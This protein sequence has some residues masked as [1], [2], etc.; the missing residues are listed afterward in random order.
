M[1]Q[2]VPQEALVDLADVLSCSSAILAK[3]LGLTNCEI[4]CIREDYPNDSREQVYQ[5]LRRWRE[6]GPDKASW[7]TLIK[8]TDSG[9]REV[10]RKHVRDVHYGE[11]T[12]E[13][14]ELCHFFS[15]KKKIHNLEQQLV[16]LDRIVFQEVQNLEQESVQLECTVSQEYKGSSEEKKELQARLARIKATLRKRKRDL[17]DNGTARHKKRSLKTG[18][19]RQSTITEFCTT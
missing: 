9:V 6:S 19:K 3:D 13:M 11:E 8:A 15:V 12:N 10:M 16:K 17:D 14:A 18:G 5:V 4:K 7:K 2:R 1:D